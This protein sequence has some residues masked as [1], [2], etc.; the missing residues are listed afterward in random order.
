M[1]RWML[2]AIVA[3]PIPFHSR[4]LHEPLI[5]EPSITL[6]AQGHVS[7]TEH[8]CLLRCQ[9]SFNIHIECCYYGPTSLGRQTCHDSVYSVCSAEIVLKTGFSRDLRGA[10]CKVST[11]G[12][13]HV[14]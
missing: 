1:Q 3:M 6:C 11:L 13:P 12:K 14:M 8:R 10:A 4:R 5:L 9:V 2:R 7:S